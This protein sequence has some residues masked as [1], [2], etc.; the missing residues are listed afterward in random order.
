MTAVLE[1]AWRTER[2]EARRAA[3]RAAR[4]RRAYERAARFT[5]ASLTADEKRA[6]DVRNFMFHGIQPDEEGLSFV[7]LA[8][9]AQGHRLEAMGTSPEDAV[10][11]LVHLASA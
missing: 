9:D 10:R 7:A 4:I 2:R 3:R 1:E 11:R 6:L 5:A 8:A